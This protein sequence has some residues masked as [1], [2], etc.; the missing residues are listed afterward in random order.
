M[1]GGGNPDITFEL[2]SSAFEQSEEIPRRHGKQIDNVSPALAW[3][4]A[5]DGTKSFALSMLDHVSPSNTYVHWLVAD[6]PADAAGI[7]E[8]A[9]GAGR[10][11]AGSRELKP[12]VGPFPPSGTHR[13]E[14]T[15]YA[16]DVNQL[17]VQPGTGIDR[18]EAA[19]APRTLGT[20][21]LTGSFTKV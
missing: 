15:L 4:G 3:T 17:D 1:A 13:Y 8:D 16:L 14:F 10:M 2:T 20:A 21:R 6:I 18:F 19:V 5:P 12:Y 9:S 11:P 7:H